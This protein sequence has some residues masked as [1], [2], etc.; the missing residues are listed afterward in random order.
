M[1]YCILSD[2]WVN[3]GQSR[4]S[5]AKALAEAF[6]AMEELARRSAVLQHSSPATRAFGRT[7]LLCCTC[8]HSRRHDT[9]PWLNFCTNLPAIGRTSNHHSVQHTLTV[10]IYLT[11]H[12]SQIHSSPGHFGRLS[13]S[14]C[15][16]R[17]STFCFAIR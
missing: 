9:R 2:R 1:T 12:Y 3:G 6:F 5:R 7:S 11:G 14:F 4:R 15:C 8:T 16:T 17:H 13:S 10:I